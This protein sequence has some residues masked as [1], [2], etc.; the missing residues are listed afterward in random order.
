MEPVPKTKIPVKMHG[1]PIESYGYIY[2][3]SAPLGG[4][5]FCKENS[6]PGSLC[7]KLVLTVLFAALAVPAFS[8]VA[9][10]AT[11][12]TGLTMAV[13]AGVSD[14]KMDYGPAHEW[15]G[16]LWLD[17]SRN[18]VPSYLRG[19]GVEIEARDLSRDRG[20]YLPNDFRTDTLGGGLKYSWRHF[21]RV[22]PYVKFLVSYGSLDITK[23]GYHFTW[24]DLAPG[25]GIDYRA[26]GSVWFRADYE[27]QDWP[28]IFGHGYDLDPQGVTLGALYEF[29]NHRSSRP[30][31]IEELTRVGKS[32]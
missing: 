14:Y 30:W 16:T 5:K 11:G 27:Y 13:G 22:R 6:M 23:T 9:P 18:H 25:G 29:G 21:H 32:Q 20:P 17:A 1:Q 4:R 12:G 24:V 7:S 10:S 19:L 28:N 15:G 2:S 3:Q 8:Q 26:F 31:K